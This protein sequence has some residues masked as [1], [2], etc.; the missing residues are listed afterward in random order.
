MTTQLE[1]AVSSFA[2]RV[3]PRARTLDVGC[4]LRPYERYFAEGEYVGID[5]EES[6]RAAG[7][8]RPDRYFNGVEIPYE[9]QTFDAIICTEVLE[10]CVDPERLTGEM[11]RVLRLGGQLLVTVPFIW[12]VHE[13]PYD[14]R[15]YSPFGVRRLLEGAGFAVEG[16]DRV[17]EGVDAI[18][19][20]VFS[21]INNY[22]VNVESE[23]KRRSA[24]VR[25]LRRLEPHV[26]RVQ[27][28]IWRRL[29]VFERIYIDNA[30]IAVKR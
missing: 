21:E 30:S 1:L 3:P 5:V 14:F 8:K 29:Y 28:A 9:D 13:A 19:M 2:E 25:L 24:R 11:Y 10:H 20:L 4:G 22:R 26:W 15:R 23:A 16:V 12:G 17:V 18:A 7:G 6:G 27:L